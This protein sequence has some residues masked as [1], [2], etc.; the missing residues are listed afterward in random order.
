MPRSSTKRLLMVTL[1]GTWSLG[2]LV[3]LSLSCLPYLRL[4]APG[5]PRIVLPDLTARPTSLVYTN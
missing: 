4:A 3:F 2:I 1:A 5:S